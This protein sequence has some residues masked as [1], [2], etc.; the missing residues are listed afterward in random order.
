MSSKGRNGKKKKTG[1]TLEAYEVTLFILRVIVS[2]Y[3]CMFFVAMPLFYHNKYFDIGDFKYTMFMYLTVTFLSLSAIML[4]IHI[5]VLGVS[6]RIR[7]SDLKERFMAMSMTDLF[8][9]AFG[10]A[11]VI[12]FLLSPIRTD[13]YPVFFL[14]NTDKDARVVNL[15]WEGYRGWN[16]G[17][18]SQ[19]MFVAMYFLISRLFMKSWK[20]DLICISLSSAFAVF[21]LGVLNRFHIDPLGMYDGLVEGYI[22]K[23]LSTLGQ[24]TWYSSFM[25]VMLPVGMAL[26]MF[27]DRKWTLDKC[28]LALYVSIGGA[29]FVTQNSD[30]AYPAFAAIIVMMFA[31]SFMNNERFLRFLEMMILM[32]GAMKVVGLFQILFPQRLTEL[33]RMSLF[34]SQSP[35]TLVLL[36]ALTGLYIVILKKTDSGRFDIIRYKRLRTAVVI[37]MAACVPLVIIIAYLNTKGMLPTDAL[38]GV[39]Y[40]T[41]ND[42]WGNNRGYTWRNTV[43]VMREPLWR[44]MIFTGPGPDCYPMVM[45]ADDIRASMMHEFWNGEIV[46]CAHNEW[47]NML[48]NEGILG[49]VTYLGIFGSAFVSCAR[50]YDNPVSLAC[51]SA[52]AGYF[53]HNMFCYQQILCTPMIFCVMALYDFLNGDKE[54]HS[55]K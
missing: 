49:F 27:C 8:V 29:T 22:N 44:S 38:A 50:K 48:F 46:I 20:K 55:E 34:V 1:V 4:V 52:I 14:F 31:I 43:E 11:S 42:S 17:L 32:L 6:G 35:V 54:M 12:S 47:L 25:V 3:C 23:F 5:I 28:L 26:Y 10:M 40:L 33:D 30:S 39:E 24:A 2:V 41:F 21:L 45:Y 53:F 13:E 36:I 18:R 19:L 9:I 16:M 7:L 15:P 51:A 37:C